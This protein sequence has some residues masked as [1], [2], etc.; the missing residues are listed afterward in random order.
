MRL[1]YIEDNERLALNTSASLRDSGFVVDVVH[2]AADV[3]N[4]TRSFLI[5]VYLIKTD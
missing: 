1:L 4:M 3:L 2:T 5:L